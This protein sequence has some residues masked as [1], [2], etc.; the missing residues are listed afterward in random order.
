MGF[1]K[2][3]FYS[4]TLVTYS[5]EI[6]VQND[7]GAE[8]VL[9]SGSG[10]SS[11]AP[12]IPQHNDFRCFFGDCLEPQSRLQVFDRFVNP[13]LYG[14]QEFRVMLTS[15]PSSR[16]TFGPGFLMCD[17]QDQDDTTKVLNRTCF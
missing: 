14:I 12:G 4:E 10:T 13:D 2:F 8:L 15:S 7:L 5:H 6:F 9:K 16:E 11:C 1:Y 17:Q 3:R